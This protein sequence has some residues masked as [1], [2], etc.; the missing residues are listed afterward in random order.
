MSTFLSS[1]A[2]WS[3]TAARR[4]WD[5][6][7]S[8][9]ALSGLARRRA[10][11]EGRARLTDERV[12]GMI[13]ERHIGLEAGVEEEKAGQARV[14][15]K[16]RQRAQRT[17]DGER[18][19][20]AGPLSPLPLSPEARRQMT[21]QAATG[22]SDVMRLVVR[23]LAGPECYLVRRWLSSISPSIHSRWPDQS[24][25]ASNHQSKLVVLLTYP[26][27]PCNQPECIPVTRLPPSRSP[28]HLPMTLQIWR[29]TSTPTTARM[30]LFHRRRPLVGQVRCK[31]WAVLSMPPL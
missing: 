4:A 2:I 21:R 17:A 27:S 18:A 20:T 5:G 11:D 9:S 31:E 25:K 1:A 30:A 16:N 19:P 24:P 15:G 28:P 12:A 8:I 22:K 26:P 10:A 14:K 29:T 23:L 6:G 3:A 7:G 13:E